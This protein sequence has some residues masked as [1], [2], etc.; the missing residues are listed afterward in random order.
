MGRL[1]RLVRTER[2]HPRWEA[3]RQIQPQPDGE[4]RFDPSVRTAGELMREAP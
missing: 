4:V 3:W 2:R 1:A